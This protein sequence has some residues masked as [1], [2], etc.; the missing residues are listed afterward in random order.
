MT[1][2]IKDLFFLTLKLNIHLNV[3]Y[4]QSD[5]SDADSP[6]RFS[7]DI[8]CSLS[9]LTWALVDASFGP[10]SV[11]LMAIPSNVKRFRDGEKPKF[12]SPHPCKESSGVNVFAQNLSMDENY[13]VFP[14]FVLIACMV[15]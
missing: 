11:D 7:S 2:E 4:V 8:D 5:L 3:Y 1:N 13:Y 15:L 10:H 12:F 9:D 14:P 6:S